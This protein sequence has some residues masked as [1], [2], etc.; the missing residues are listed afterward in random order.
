M[1]TKSVSS[2]IDHLAIH[3][4][5]ITNQRALE[6][7]GVLDRL[8]SNE[9][10]AHTITPSRPVLATLTTFAASPIPFSARHSSSSG[11]NRP[12]E[13]HRSPGLARGRARSH[14]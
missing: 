5:E 2:P 4:G 10:E 8:R 14:R 11:I 3:A 13:R 9:L 7:V 1:D 12:P 6:N